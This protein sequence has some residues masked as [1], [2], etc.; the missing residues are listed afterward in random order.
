[1]LHTGQRE[2]SVQFLTQKE[3]SGVK[4]G[5]R[6][7]NATRMK[8]IMHLLVTV[9]I[10]FNHQYDARLSRDFRLLHRGGKGR[11]YVHPIRRYVQ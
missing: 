11:V 7:R 4:T 2:I 6:A 10:A 9:A 5:L 8:T 1:M 3:R